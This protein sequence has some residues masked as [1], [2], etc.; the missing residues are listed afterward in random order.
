MNLK[1]IIF[2]LGI[3][4]FPISLLAFLNILYSIYFDHLINV[5][6]YMI[7]LFTSFIAGAL[8]Y[9]YGKNA[10]KRL[11]FFDQIILLIFTYLV[12]SLLISIVYFSSNYN[13]SFIN[14]IFE[15]FSG[16]TLTGFSIFESV[17]YLDPTV[18]IWRSSSQ[19]IG[20][21]Y[22]LIFL[23]L[24]FNNKQFYFKS[25]NLTYSFDSSLNSENKIKDD[26]IKITILYLT[27]SFL[28]FFLLTFAQIRL[29]NGLNLS[30]S[31]ISTGGFLPTDSL[32]NIIKTPIQK[33]SLLLSIIISIVNLFFIFN[34]FKKGAILRNHQEDLFLIGFYL[35]SSLILIFFLK[36]FEILDIFINVASSLSNSGISIKSIPS[37]FT[38]YFLFLTIVGGSLISNTS[39]IKLIR[40]YILLKSTT[41][42]ILK[43]VRPNNI[44]SQ[45]IL[46]S[47][48]KITNETIKISFFIFISF[49]L[50]IFALSGIMIFDTINFEDAFKISVL[51][52]TNTV[53]SDIYG[54]RDIEFIN[55]LTSSKIGLIIF[56]VIGKVELISIFLII[57]KFLIKN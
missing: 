45:N 36:N 55:L 16:V 30:M 19:W 5:N 22:F 51:T 7:T 28:I 31:L 15:S 2:Y 35:I 41:T 12:S 42:E 52:L 21:L 9:F 44:V 3:L 23:I 26:V 46:F 24:L 18:I 39:G 34:I 40:I 8:F 1:G 20:G 10:K 4:C 38:L 43:L 47:N 13:I 49:F 11:V 14:S 54:L 17:K 48:K 53:N 37:N 25:I 32:E 33:F 50:S 27:L 6:S 29:F 57:K 56:M